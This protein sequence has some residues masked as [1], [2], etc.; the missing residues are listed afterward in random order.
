M[1]RSR[2]VAVLL[3]FV[4]SAPVYAQ[5]CNWY[6][7]GWRFVVSGVTQWE[8]ELGYSD[9]VPT[10][11][12]KAAHCA[13]VGPAGW[14]VRAPLAWPSDHSFVYSSATLSGDNCVIS[15]TSMSGSFGPFNRNTTAGYF[16]VGPNCTE[17][18]IEECE[19]TTE[20]TSV[21]ASSVPSNACNPITHC[22]MKRGAGICI[23]LSCVF[24]VTHTTEQCDSG[25]DPPVEP[26]DSGEQCA[27]G[28]EVEFCKSSDS[29][30]GKNCGFVNGEFACIDAVKPGECKVLSSGAR[31]CSQSAGTPPAPDNGT[32]GQPATPDE[33]LDQTSSTGAAAT[34]NYFNSTTVAGSARDPGTTGENPY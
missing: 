15:G 34:Y 28:A 17:P 1:L 12:A 21:V 30:A 13:A 11:A 20:S 9:G 8:S 18:P 25:I 22:K 32:A 5:T 23:G 27:E 19:N 33:T 14:A 3:L 16:A 31:I 6:Q 7:F 10:T 26:G 24:S 2:L 29:P 4:C